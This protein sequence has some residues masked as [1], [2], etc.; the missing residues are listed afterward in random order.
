MF[1]LGV[2]QGAFETLFVA[3]LPRLRPGALLVCDRAPVSQLA[4]PWLAR[5]G[6][7]SLGSVSVPL[8]AGLEFAVLS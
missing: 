7:G 4:A 2:W 1:R 3:L 8:G 5:L 6:L